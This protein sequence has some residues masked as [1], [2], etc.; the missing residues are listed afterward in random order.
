MFFLSSQKRS[1][2]AWRP[3]L[4]F[5]AMTKV[6]Q[7]PKGAEDEVSAQVEREARAAEQRGKM[8]IIV[9]V[10]CCGIQLLFTEEA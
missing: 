5:P 7:S 9:T 8:R 6:P 10:A 2:L 4:F 3:S 1:A